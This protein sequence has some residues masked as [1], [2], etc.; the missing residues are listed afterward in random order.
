MRAS[1]VGMRERAQS[2]SATTTAAPASQ[3]PGVFLLMALRWYGYGT[4]TAGT[5]RTVSSANDMA[6]ALA[7]IKSA[8]A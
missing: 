7:T 5:P 4:R 1:T 2:S 3:L 6:P 8:A